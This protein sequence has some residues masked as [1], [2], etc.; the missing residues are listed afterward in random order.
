ML[1]KSELMPK[2]ENALPKKQPLLIIKQ[3]VTVAVFRFAK[4]GPSTLVPDGPVR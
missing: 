2:P 4:D 3:F 1:R